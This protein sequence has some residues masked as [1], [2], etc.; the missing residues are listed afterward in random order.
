MNIKGRCYW[1]K[2]LATKFINIKTASAKLEHLSKAMLTHVNLFGSLVV[3]LKRD[4]D[5]L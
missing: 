3:L 5:F 4:H 2:V 1:S